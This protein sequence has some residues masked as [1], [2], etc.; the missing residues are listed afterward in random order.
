MYKGIVVYMKTHPYEPVFY[1]RLCK[2]YVFYPLPV[3][4][5]ANSFRSIIKAIDEHEAD[6]NVF[7][8][9][10]GQR[11][12]F[13]EFNGHVKQ[14]GSLTVYHV[15][16]KS[17]LLYCLAQDKVAFKR[18]RS[19]EYP[20]ASDFSYCAKVVD[21]SASLCIPYEKWVDSLDIE[22]VISSPENT[23]VFGELASFV[24]TYKRIK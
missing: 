9:H 1:E 24:S 16:E 7:V 14:H 23:D 15:E 5:P 13:G 2:K 12:Y 10:K 20:K 8:V 21:G 11:A 6:P 4:N 22:K 18:A 17:N 3:K 19:T